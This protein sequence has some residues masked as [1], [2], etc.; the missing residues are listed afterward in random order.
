MTRKLRRPKFVDKLN[1]EEENTDNNGEENTSHAQS[2]S[3]TT[4]TIC[5]T[6]PP[7][8]TT[9][10]KPLTAENSNETV[11]SSENKPKR[12]R[13][14]FRSTELNRSESVEQ[15]S[16][17]RTEDENKEEKK[18]EKNLSVV[19]E[20]KEQQSTKRGRRKLD[21]TRIFAQHKNQEE[22]NDQEE[23]KSKKN[24]KS[25]IEN[26]V[27]D[28]KESREESLTDNQKRVPSEATNVKKR[29]F[30]RKY[31]IQQESKDVEIMEH[32]KNEQS[33]SE[34][35]E[36]EIKE[37][38]T[39]TALK[40]GKSRLK[41]TLEDI[42]AA[43]QGAALNNEEHENMEY[44]KDYEE[45]TGEF[46]HFLKETKVPKK[47]TKEEY[48][49]ENVPDMK[50]VAKSDNHVEER[51]HSISFDNESQRARS[52]S[53]SSN[54]TPFD[55]STHKSYKI[56]RHTPGRGTESPK[57]RRSIHQ[58]DEARPFKVRRDDQYPKNYP[59]RRDSF[60]SYK[61]KESS[62]DRHKAPEQGGRF[63]PSRY[64]KI[65][66]YNRSPRKRSDSS[67]YR[68]RDYSPNN[69]YSYSNRG[70]TRYDNDNNLS[71]RTE[72]HPYQRNYSRAYSNDNRGRNSSRDRSDYRSRS[73]ELKDRKEIENVTSKM[74]TTKQEEPNQ[75]TIINVP[76]PAI[77]R[78]LLEE[79]KLNE[80]ASFLSGP[81][82]ADPISQ[83]L[84]TSPLQNNMT[85]SVNNSTP[86][87]TGLNM[88]STNSALPAQNASSVQNNVATAR[89][90]KMKFDPFAED[91]S[92]NIT[93]I[94]EPA[95]ADSPDKK[96][97]KKKVGD[98]VLSMMQRYYKN[99]M[100]ESKEEFKEICRTITHKIA[101]KENLS[102]LSSAPTQTK[103]RDYIDKFVDKYIAKKKKE[104]QKQS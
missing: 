103:I 29:R 67:D 23:E 73:N 41:E 75:A 17:T 71:N 21:R 51:D 93:L 104:T 58:E 2:T 13:F 72:Y 52:N 37:G 27:K 64:D 40:K 56:S 53:K 14:F 42:N 18:E 38:N 7:N 57:R 46:S 4:D 44:S 48:S 102:S 1:A 82:K 54:Y 66:T 100:I 16:T 8:T 60:S 99:R 86:A 49:H 31:E 78:E 36:A 11:L 39:S 34:K 95:L 92:R 85:S 59:E 77:D 33:I 91:K 84:S 9:P 87:S 43:E 88:H 26:T 81:T 89:E 12:R 74:P 20:E 98:I 83:I 15:N 50:H 62:H 76:P 22:V 94:I 65:D 90:S 25:E 28:M 24:D 45:I 79:F 101:K 70:K 5:S 35:R 96:K 68:R 97:L 30:N 69:R 80:T 63:S 55:K 19:T 10:S 61:P 6:S 3:V 47:N 32:V